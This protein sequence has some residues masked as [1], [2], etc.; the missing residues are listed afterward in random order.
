M[1]FDPGRFVQAQDR[2][3]EQARRELCD[4][5]KRSHWMWFVFPQL[6]NLGYSAMAQQYAV[7]SLNEA[8][9]SRRTARL[10]LSY[11]D[12]S[13]TEIC[14]GGFGN[15]SDHLLCGFCDIGPGPLIP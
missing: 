7:A 13:I 5:R 6:S 12:I 1:R 9:G 3:F 10:C 11:H 2:V 8:E 4:G 15:K 14:V